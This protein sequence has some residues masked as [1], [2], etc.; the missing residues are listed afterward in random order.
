MSKGWIGFAIG[1]ILAMLATGI[2]AKGETNM[3]EFN[4][5]IEK[6]E[7]IDSS[8]LTMEMIRNRNGKIII[9][10]CIGV[11][12]DAEGNGK[13]LNYNDPEHYYIGYRNVKGAKPG[14][15]ILSYFIYNPENNIEDD[16]IYRY[17]Y[18]L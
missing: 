9:E 1:V 5:A 8:D 11:V 12:L 16:I 13:V 18:I 17:D 2:W 4:P 15:T 14:D 7:I 10:R 3:F 6:V